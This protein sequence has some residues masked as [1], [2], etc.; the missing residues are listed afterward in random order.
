MSDRFDFNESYVDVPPAAVDAD[1][2]KTIR[3][4]MFR[5]SKLEHALADQQAEASGETAEVMRDLVAL[6]DDLN[7][8]VQRWGIA[9]NAQEAALVR[10]V[11]GL[12]RKLQQILAKQEVK[13]IAVVGQPLNPQTSD[14]AAS[15][16]STSMQPNTV[17][18]E[19]EPGYTWRGGLLRKARVVISTRPPK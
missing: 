2:A 14:I 10:A 5:V 13:P 16:I 7:Q 11:V 18:R 1:P 19:M 8:I 15:E 17:L 12:G 6:E 3:E 4:L 9:T